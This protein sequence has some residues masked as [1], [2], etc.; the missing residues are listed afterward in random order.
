MNQ[1]LNPFEELL[2]S[3]VDHKIDFM[4][5]GGLACVLN[6]HVRATEDVDLII[7]RTKE[8]IQR[9]ISFLSSYGQGY[10]GELSESDFTD[11]EGAIRV[12]EEFP[13]DI[14]V[15]MGGRH[16]EDLEKYKQTEDVLGRHIPYLNK[17]GLILLKQ[18]SVREKDKIDVVHLSKK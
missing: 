17:E 9:L 6:G 8:N 14:F 3:L 18:N 5:V 11:E 13:I 12:I 15:V 4:T 2:V 16:F 10:G 7:K 1:T